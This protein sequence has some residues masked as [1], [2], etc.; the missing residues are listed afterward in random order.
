[1]NN[2]EIV[3]IYRKKI[4]NGFAKLYPALKSMYER[5][6]LYKEDIYTAQIPKWE[7]G[8]NMGDVPIEMHKLV[9]DK[10]AEEYLIS[11]N[12][13]IASVDAPTP[14][15][16]ELWQYYKLVFGKLFPVYALS[17]ELT[18]NFI[19]HT[20]EIEAGG[21]WEMINGKKT[22]VAINNESILPELNQVM[23]NIIAGFQLGFP[24]KPPAGTVQ[25]V[26]NDWII[27]YR[28]NSRLAIEI[29]YHNRDAIL[30]YYKYSFK[31]YD[32]FINRFAII[33]HLNIL[34]SFGLKGISAR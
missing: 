25:G 26:P 3:A 30:N 29:A 18:D 9:L 12:D 1:M 17:E 7:D 34:N 33:Q 8:K 20:Y 16:V 24:Y 13:D 32:N 2:W 4:D 6:I 27:D 28:N 31:E 21:R 11:V 10:D 22:L 15:K 19:K 14:L 23:I 5:D